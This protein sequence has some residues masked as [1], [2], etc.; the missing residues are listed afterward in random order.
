MPD[1]KKPRSPSVE[2]P[3]LLLDEGIYYRNYLKRTNRNFNVRHIKQDLKLEGISD[4]EVYN[5]AIKEERVLVT[6]NVKHFRNLVNGEKPSIIGVSPNLG[7]KRLDQTLVSFLKRLK[8]ADF[9][10]KFFPL[11]GETRF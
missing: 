3:K 5:I 9:K 10:G 11:T 8:R 7:D 6:F 1:K 2:K 4:L